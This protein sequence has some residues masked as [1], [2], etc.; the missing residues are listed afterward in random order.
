M[1]TT[2]AAAP[3]SKGQTILG[4]ILAGLQIALQALPVVLQYRNA[5][6]SHPT[7]MIQ[8]IVDAAHDV[9]PVTGQIVSAALSQPTS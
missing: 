7:A 8:P 4:Y 2:P 1:S 6:G 9:H 5:F 3:E